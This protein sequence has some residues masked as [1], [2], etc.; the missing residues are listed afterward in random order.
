MSG[1]DDKKIEKA[2]HDYLLSQLLAEVKGTNARFDGL[3]MRVA[4]AMH[5]AQLA[6]VLAPKLKDVRRRVRELERRHEEGPTTVPSGAAKRQ[7]MVPPKFNPEDSGSYDL[8][9][10]VMAPIKEWEKYS[11]RI[12]RRES[13]MFRQRRGAVVAIVVAIL[14]GGGGYIFA[15][16]SKTHEVAK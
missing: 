11:A 1:E 16:L 10:E 4:R 15:Q 6:F 7:A 8:P 9:P 3:E 5:G 2:T 14:A 12:D 13:F